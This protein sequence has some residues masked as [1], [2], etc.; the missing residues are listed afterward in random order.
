MKKFGYTDHAIEQFVSRCDNT[1][2]LI[3]ARNLLESIDLSDY[4]LL[5]ERT[6]DDAEQWYIKTLG[7]VAI[8]RLEK[9]ENVVVTIIDEAKSVLLQKQK[10]VDIQRDLVNEYEH[11][12]TLPELLRPKVFIVEENSS[13]VHLTFMID[14]HLEISNRNRLNDFVK[15]ILGSLSRQIKHNWVKGKYYKIIRSEVQR[16]R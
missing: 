5:P 8:T 3:D 15:S 13:N 1:L 2:S 10:L 11:V 6:N 4:V 16:I 14:V 7:I 12:K 9:E